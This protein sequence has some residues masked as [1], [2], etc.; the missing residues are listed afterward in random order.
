MYKDLF[1]WVENDYMVQELL[2][3]LF[4]SF[5]STVQRLL[6]DHLPGEEHHSVTDPAVLE[7]TKTVPTTNVS[8]KGD[9]VIL[10]RLM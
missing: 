3:L 8:P 7:E 5:A 6:T 4:R 1:I 10:D 9:F 2:Q